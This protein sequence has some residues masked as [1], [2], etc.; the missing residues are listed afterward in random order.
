MKSTKTFNN[1]SDKLRSEIPKLKHGERVVFQMLNGVPNPEPDEKERK[2]QGETLYGKVQIPTNFRIY[3]PYQTPV[4]DEKGEITG[5]DG[6]YVDVGCVDV[7]DKG[8]PFKFRFFTPGLIAGQSN[9]SFFQGKFELMGGNIRDEELFEIL[10]LSNEREGNPHADPTVKKSFKLLNLKAET[11]KTLSKYDQVKKALDIVKEMKPSEAAKVLSALNKPTY[12]DEELIM[13]AV[14]EIAMTDYE[15]FLKV[16]SDPET[17]AK[18]VIKKALDAAIISHEMA[19]GDIKM[20]KTKIGIVSVEGIEDLP[21]AIVKWL[22][23]AENGKDVMANIKKQLTE[24]EK[25]VKQ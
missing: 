11:T 18:F 22:A 6:G 20:G 8:E 25:P 10:W 15:S 2:K 24:V 12:Q 4:K 14:K 9:G 5:Y 1:I 21:G 23:S 7:W 19:T 17:D 3:D 13:A 16:Y